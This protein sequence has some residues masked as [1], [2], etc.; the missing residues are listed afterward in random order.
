MTED[1]VLAIIAIGIAVASW[2]LAAWC[3]RR[4]RRATRALVK[5]HESSVARGR[6]IEHLDA[7][8]TKARS[9]VVDLRQ[10]AH[11]HEAWIADADTLIRDMVPRLKPAGISPRLHRRARALIGEPST[12]A[13]DAA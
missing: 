4:G 8:L 13:E 9:E 5:M 11:D 10:I 2:L 1:R 6:T 12:P 7:E 3:L